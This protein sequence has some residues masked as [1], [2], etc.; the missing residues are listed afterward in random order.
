MP[1][2]SFV[3]EIKY[4]IWFP[5]VKMLST[6]KQCDL[7]QFS[8]VMLKSVYTLA[9]GDF[10]LNK[11]VILHYKIKIIEKIDYIDDIKLMY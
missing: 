8:L 7:F 11:L 5:I 4:T 1:K 3:T 6:S 2:Q 10:V 9:Q